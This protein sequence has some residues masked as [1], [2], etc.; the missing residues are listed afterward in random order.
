MKA[1]EETPMEAVAAAMAFL[2]WMLANKGRRLDA[3]YL[4][5]TW[6]RRRSSWTRR[7][8]TT[9]RA[10]EKKRAPLS[11]ATFE[12]SCMPFALD[13][14]DADLIR[15]MRNRRRRDK[16]AGRSPRGWDEATVADLQR[17]GP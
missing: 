17:A 12:P 5:S 1:V 10:C 8:G 13:A 11:P 15:R 3:A 9:A 14:T 16:K 7:D 6:A 4:R 2:A